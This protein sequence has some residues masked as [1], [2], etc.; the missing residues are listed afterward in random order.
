MGWC[1]YLGKR[2]GLYYQIPCAGQGG[3]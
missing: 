3:L 1:S 2:F